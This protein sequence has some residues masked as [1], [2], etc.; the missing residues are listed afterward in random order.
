M[1]YLE[2]NTKSKTIKIKND[3]RHIK[4]PFIVLNQYEAKLILDNNEV[5][6][7][8][9]YC[10]LKYYCN[11]SPTKNTDFTIKQF[12]KE[13]GYSENSNAYIS[14]IS[15]YNSYLTSLKI[16]Q[17]KKYRDTSGNERNLYSLL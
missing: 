3:I 9:Y 5:L 11:F 12:L 15:S 13:T 4:I 10:Y 8:K 7:G 1:Y 2:S 14:K 16:L 6:F 17:I